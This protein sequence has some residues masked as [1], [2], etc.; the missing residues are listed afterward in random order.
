MSADLVIRD[1]MRVQ[2]KLASVAPQE[3]KQMSFLKPGSEKVE[4]V[5]APNKGK[6]GTN[7]VAAVIAGLVHGTVVMMAFASFAFIIFGSSEH[8][9]LRQAFSL[10]ISNQLM[11]AS[12]LI[13]ALTFRGFFPFS[14]GGPTPP[15]AL[16]MADVVR[17]AV[18]EVVDPN[19][20][21]P[22]AFFVVAAVSVLMGIIL[23]FVSATKTAVYAQQLPYPVLCGF[24]GSVVVLLMRNAIGSL[25]GVPLVYLFWPKDFGAASELDHSSLSANLILG[26]CV[27]W[28]LLFGVPLLRAK[29]KQGKALLIVLPAVFV[30]PVLTFYI[31]VAIGDFDLG[32]SGA[33]RSVKP[34]WLFPLVQ[35]QP[36]WE[37][38]V[39]FYS[40]QQWDLQAVTSALPQMVISALLCAIAALI[41]M[42]G[43]EANAPQSK[44]LD[45]NREFSALGWAVL[46]TGGLGGH[47]GHH[48]AAFTLP[49]KR[50]GGSSRVA[51]WTASLLWL[52]VFLSGLPLSSFIPRFFL[53]GCF[54]QVGFGLARTFLWDNRK[55][56]DLASQSIAWITVIVALVSDLNYAT[57]AA[58]LLVVLRFVNM[59][60]NMNV[61]RAVSRADM[62]RSPKY[63]SSREVE[64][65][66]KFGHRIM[67]L[68]LE[69][70]LFWGTVDE[71]SA[72]FAELIDGTEDDPSTIFV[73]L[74]YITGVE[75][76]V[77][78]VLK[79]LHRLAGNV[80]INITLTSIPGRETLG[81]SWDALSALPFMDQRDLAE[82]LE[83]SEDQLISGHSDLMATGASDVA[84]KHK[85]SEVLQMVAKTFLSSSEGQLLSEIF[86][87]WHLVCAVFKQELRHCRTSLKQEN[88]RKY[89]DEMHSAYGIRWELVQDELRVCQTFLPEWRV[90]QLVLRSL[91]KE[92]AIQTYVSCS[93]HYC[94]SLGQHVHGHA[95]AAPPSAPLPGTKEMVDEGLQRGGPSPKRLPLFH[96]FCPASE[97]CAEVQELMAES[98]L[99]DMAPQQELAKVEGMPVD[100]LSKAWHE[101]KA[102]LCR[103]SAKLS[104]E[105][106][107]RRGLAE[108]FG[109]HQFL[110][111]P[112][113]GS[114][115][116]LGW[117][118]PS[119]VDVELVQDISLTGMDGPA[120]LKSKLPG[121]LCEATVGVNRNDAGEWSALTQQISF[122]LLL[123]LGT[124]GRLVKCCKGESPLST[125]PATSSDLSPN[126]EDLAS[127]NKEGSEDVASELFVIVGG[128][129]GTFTPADT[130]LLKS[131]AGSVLGAEDMCARRPRS[132]KLS[133]LSDSGLL[134]CIDRKVLVSLEMSDSPLVGPAES[135][136]FIEYLKRELALNSLAVQGSLSG[137]ACGA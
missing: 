131:G 3:K 44:G 111:L 96:A 114:L 37:V 38:W 48:V 36:F 101:G 54:L 116:E 57:M 71:I 74:R 55:G 66:E 76:S 49:M 126:Q 93:R 113:D 119:G 136:E 86:K 89:V 26:F 109:I 60:M 43:I 63:R 5:A 18:D 98:V 75:I 117:V 10:G 52:L 95:S 115:I 8:V 35:P 107:P 32:A 123:A 51:P 53:G 45:L 112:I 2:Q 80:G 102:L 84:P 20:K 85:N 127:G 61:V 47:P 9:E 99:I 1:A 133:C 70:Y 34:S 56:L 22:T 68:Y 11:S 64:I 33:L 132:V 130:L 67:V 122:N 16:L 19:K 103:N 134:I 58:T 106:F 21:V 88:L 29:I 15:A 91:N 14:M 25:V 31:A 77:V 73:D 100:L 137:S 124:M 46:F 65:L 78:N 90:Q 125:Q 97:E 110:Y 39:N 94:V 118:S 79:K 129:F 4:A 13:G 87:Q 83:E 7:P 24:L 108:K 30:L 81:Q 41:N 135:K 69:G 12:V 104:Q 6:A 72:A 59:S 23:L 92:E 82:L 42:A 28:S 40:P 62:R 27:A 121:S 120:A 17:V 128:S 105:V 50:D